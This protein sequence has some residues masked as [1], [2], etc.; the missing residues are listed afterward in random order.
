MSMRNLMSLLL[1][2]LPLGVQAECEIF[3]PPPAFDADRYYAET[4][5][6]QD[7]TLEKVL[8]RQI[9]GHHN[10]GLECAR[11]LA[12]NNRAWPASQGFP[13]DIQDAHG[14]AHNLSDLIPAVL[15]L[16]GIPAEVPASWRGDYARRLFYM[17][18]RYAGDDET[19]TPDLR[20]VRGKPEKGQPHI[21]ALCDLL[22]WHAQ[23]P[24]SEEERRHQQAVYARQGNRNPF[25]D[26]P[27]FAAAIWQNECARGT[28]QADTL[29][30]LLQRIE[31]METELADLKRRVKELR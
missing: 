4:V 31:A 30:N 5:D 13:D 6:L 28:A 18:V 19:L 15:L 21:G 9:K 1:V 26:R 10:L 23:D 17:A 2:A 11:Q 29:D 24:V 20:L 12:G 27:A 25:I 16:E 8:N 3:P 22:Q 14:D 7:A